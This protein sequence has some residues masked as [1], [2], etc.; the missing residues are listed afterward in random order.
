MNSERINYLL[1]IQYQF[2]KGL[3]AEYEIN[4]E[5]KQDLL[6][7]YQIQND[8]KM[9]NNQERTLALFEEFKNIYTNEI[10]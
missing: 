7:L 2:K 3:I 8:E 6:K 10:D 4:D 5:D 9:K 1:N